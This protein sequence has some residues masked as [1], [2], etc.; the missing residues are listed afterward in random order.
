MRITFVVPFITLT[1]GIRVVYEYANRLQDR[2][3][4]VTVVHPLIPMKL[5]AE[6]HNIRGLASQVLGLLG[7]I[8]RGNKI[9]WFQLKTPL[10]RALYFPEKYRIPPLGRYV[11]DGDVV[12][13]TAWPTAYFVNNL[14]Q[15]KGEKFYFIQH[16]ESQEVWNERQ[17]WD[18]AQKIEEDPLRLPLTVVDQNTSHLWFHKRRGKIDGTYK[19]PLHKITISSWLKA[20]LEEKF[21]QRVEASIVNGVNSKEFFNEHKQYNERKRVLMLHHTAKWK[22]VEDGIKAFE[23]TRERRPE[24]QLVMFSAYPPDHNTPSYAEFH[25]NIHGEDLRKLYCSCDIF[26]CP[27]WVEGS[28]LPPMEAM[29]CKCALA[30]TSVGGVPDYTIPGKTALVSPPRAPELLAKNIIMLLE[31]ES[32]L[33]HI[34]EAGYEHIMNFTWDKATDKLEQLFKDVLNK[35]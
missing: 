21:G 12:V 7:N 33:R 29:A 25:Q 30:A 18:N 2:G 34:S 27:S 35:H 1:G 8:K 3:H 5:G 28:Q 17:L 10:K 16:Y 32:L 15:K 20:L 19:L 24:I 31:D 13:A 23:I 14:S 9:H 11:P 4:Q 6:W 26:L 22:G